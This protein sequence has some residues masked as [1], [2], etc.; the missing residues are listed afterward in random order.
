VKFRHQQLLEILD[1]SGP[2][3]F[4]VHFLVDSFRVNLSPAFAIESTGYFAMKALVCI[5]PIDLIELGLVV[6]YRAA[7][8]EFA[9]FDQ[10][11]SS[12]LKASRF[13][14]AFIEN[15]LIV[16]KSTELVIE[17]IELD[18]IDILIGRM[19]SS[20]GYSSACK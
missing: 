15:D 9:V 17:M 16:D 20:M 2:Q 8:Q 4:F 19:T 5:E 12:D 14:Y 13:G 18:K 6:L 11:P 3:S 10:T 7:I 1:H